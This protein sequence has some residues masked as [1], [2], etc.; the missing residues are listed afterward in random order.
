MTRM[1]QYHDIYETQAKE[2]EK[3]LKLTLRVKIL[4]DAKKETRSKKEMKKKTQKI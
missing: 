2:V 4:E 3:R 1:L